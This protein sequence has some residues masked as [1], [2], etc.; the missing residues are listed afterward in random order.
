M[1]SNL[2]VKILEEDAVIRSKLYVSKHSMI[3]ELM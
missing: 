3:F 2:F 1:K